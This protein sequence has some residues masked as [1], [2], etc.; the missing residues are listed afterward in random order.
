MTELRLNWN[1]TT[2]YHRNNSSN[3]GGK[4]VTKPEWFCS[5]HVSPASA[6]EAR[7]N[8]IKCNYSPMKKALLWERK[9]P[10]TP[11]LQTI[12]RFSVVHSKLTWKKSKWKHISVS[13][14]KTHVIISALNKSSGVQIQTVYPQTQQHA[15]TAG[16]ST[17]LAFPSS[18]WVISDHERAP[19]NTSWGLHS[20]YTPTAMSTDHLFSKASCLVPFSPFPDVSFGLNWPSDNVGVIMQV[21]IDAAT[22]IFYS[23]GAG[24]GVLIAFASYNKFDN[25]CYR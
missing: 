15:C 5:Q 7:K 12:F 6:S 21:W 3:Q 22:Q 2:V 11:D 20:A 10:V 18:C 9:C 16:L 19:C 17:T 23:L 14:K 1:L 4:K 24:F 13:Q 8:H 25:N